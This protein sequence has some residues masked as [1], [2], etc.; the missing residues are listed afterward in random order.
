[1]ELKPGK[2]ESPEGSNIIVGHTHFDHALE[3]PIFA[4]H[5][6][7]PLIGNASLET[8]MTMYGKSGRVIVC[9]GSERVELPGSAVVT[10]IPSIHGLASFDRAP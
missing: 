8:L 7:R 5:F 10:V 2:W 1:M 9:K 4:E 3:I 6:D